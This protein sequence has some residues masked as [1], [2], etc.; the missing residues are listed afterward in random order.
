MP[1]WPAQRT[2]GQK[3]PGTP[4]RQEDISGTAAKEKIW[5][6]KIGYQSWDEDDDT[7]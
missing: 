1:T 7:V 2:D 3:D 5:S 6:K 4:G